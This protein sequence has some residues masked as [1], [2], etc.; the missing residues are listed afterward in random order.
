MPDEKLNQAHRHPREKSPL[1]NVQSNRSMPDSVV[2]P[3][4]AYSDVSQAV[5]WLCQVFGFE[6]RLRIGDHRVQLTYNQGAVVVIRLP[7]VEEGQVGALLPERAA[8]AHSI[9]VRVL[10][11]DA[12][13]ERATRQGA[14][15]LH[16]LVDYPYGERQYSVLDPGGHIWTFSQT[17]T[18][19]DPASWGGKLIE[20][21]SDPE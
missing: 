18:D 15:V 19:V 6:E 12:H 1:G 4:L 11:I 17:I 21:R 5:A 2:I 9:M 13:Y 7:A 3:V 8:P 16:P 10:E 14:Q 20:R